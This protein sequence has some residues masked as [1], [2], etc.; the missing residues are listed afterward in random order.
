MKILFRGFGF[1]IFCLLSQH[2]KAQQPDSS[3]I[4]LPPVMEQLPATAYKHSIYAEALGNAIVGSI[5]YE[6]LISDKKP[7]AVIAWRIGM[8]FMPFGSTGGNF[9]YEILVP[10]EVTRFHGNKAIKLEYGAGATI[11]FSSATYS[12]IDGSFENEKQTAIAPVL[13]IGGRYQMP[14]TPYFIRAGFTPLLISN[15]F[16]GIPVVP[17][18]GISVGYSFGSR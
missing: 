8:L 15:D 5:N 12:S 4:S 6:R 11:Y 18:G 17:Y 9:N 16:W 3:A 14:G 1:I 13:R 10:I 7:G 2:V